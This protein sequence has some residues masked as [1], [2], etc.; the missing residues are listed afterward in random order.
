[1]AEALAAAEASSKKLEQTEEEA[2]EAEPTP[3]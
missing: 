2:K 1:V 3:D